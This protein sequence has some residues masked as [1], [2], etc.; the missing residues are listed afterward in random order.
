[1][2]LVFDWNVNVFFNC[3]LILRIK[4]IGYIFVIFVISVSGEILDGVNL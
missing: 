4:G 3:G 2:L 1:M